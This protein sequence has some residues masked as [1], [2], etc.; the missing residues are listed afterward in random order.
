VPAPGGEGRPPVDID[1]IVAAFAC[2][3]AGR[4]H[5]HQLLLAQQL[6]TEAGQ[7][8]GRIKHGDVERAGAQLFQ[9]LVRH[10]DMGV[11]GDVGPPGTHPHQPVEQQRVPQAELAA[12]RQRPGA[13]GRQGEL[14]A[15]ALPDLHEGLREAL[16]LAAGR[17]QP[18]A[19]AV[20]DEKLAAQPLLQRADAR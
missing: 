8:L 16:E 14:V 19:V 5:Q 3:V 18:R 9:K 12:Q 4:A 6:D 7:E 20:S 2:V 13:A 10:A 17:R 1:V 11:D 15:G